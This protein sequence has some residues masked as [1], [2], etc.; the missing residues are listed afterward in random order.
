MKLYI[1]IGTVKTGSSFMQ[2]FLANNRDLLVKNKV[3]FPKAGIYEKNMIQGKISPGNAGGLNTYLVSQNWKNVEKWLLIR[4]NEAELNHC[5][6]MLLTNELL[7]FTFSEGDTLKRF[8]ELIQK[9]G[10]QWENMLLIIR[11]PTPQA[12][13]FYQHRSKNG[14]MKPIEVWLKEEYTISESLKKFYNK[15]DEEAIELAQFPYQKQ[16]QYLIDVMLNYWMGFNE[17]VEVKESK[18]VNKSLTLSELKLLSYVEKK[19]TFLAKKFYERMLNIPQEL[20]SEDRYIKEMY[21]QKIDVYLSKENQLW[22]DCN[23]R[24]IKGEILIPK[25]DENKSF[26]AEVMSFSEYQLEAFSELMTSPLHFSYWT[27]SFAFKARKIIKSMLP[28]SLNKKI[29]ELKSNV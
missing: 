14:N 6:S 9:L 8:K 4:K 28:K 20:K 27:A 29:A 16:S 17:K 13:S 26:D 11:N 25:A 23:K 19:D 22:S 21:L 18:S 3:H 7:L 12:L 1:H 15:I 2:S 5:E 10:F 24:M